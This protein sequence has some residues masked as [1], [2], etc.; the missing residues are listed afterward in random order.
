MLKL[1]RRHSN[2]VED[3]FDAGMERIHETRVAT[4]TTCACLHEAGHL[5]TAKHTGLIIERAWIPPV[6]WFFDPNKG[7][8]GVQIRNEGHAAA[9]FAFC[10][11]GLFGEINP[12]YDDEIRLHWRDLYIM[13]AGAI[14]DLRHAA[15]LSP[16]PTV[17]ATIRA[18]L[19]A[20]DDATNRLEFLR[21]FPFYDLPEF[22]AFRKHRKEHMRLASEIYRRWKSNKFG[23]LDLC[24]F[25]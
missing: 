11:S 4:V 3:L 16:D 24:E 15:E 21:H 1:W 10:M 2:A 18:A 13:S 5:L 22:H 19:R 12:Y 7:Y 23:H 9:I 25:V 14:G 8:P 17:A 20:S 6:D